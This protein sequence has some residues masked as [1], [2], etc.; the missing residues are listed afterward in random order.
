M[1]QKI[2]TPL[3]QQSNFTSSYDKYGEINSCSS[4]SKKVIF[5]TKNYKI[6]PSRENKGI[7][8]CLE[9]AEKR[10]GALDFSRRL[11]NA[12]SNGTSTGEGSK[13]TKVKWAITKTSKSKT[14]GNAGKGLHFKSLS[15]KRGILGSLFTI[16][17]KKW[18]KPTCHKF[19]GSKLVHSLQTL[20]DE[21]LALSD[22]GFA[23]RD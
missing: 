18:R 19:E 7:S 4:S 15:L 17:K 5:Q 11:R 23:K 1:F 12:S 21:R 22:V 6:F 9:T 2:G 3:Q 8:P 16:S 20:Q 14:E 10:S 13:S